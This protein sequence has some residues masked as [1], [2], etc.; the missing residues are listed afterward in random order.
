ML[1]VA[2]ITLITNQM[3]II[4]SVYIC[5]LWGYRSYWTILN[6]TQQQ[7]LGGELLTY[8]HLLLLLILYFNEQKKVLIRYQYV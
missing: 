5:E 4:I 6:S 3:Y 8:F 2:I 7:N 1:D